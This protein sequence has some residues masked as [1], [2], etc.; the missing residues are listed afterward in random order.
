MPC[1]M[2]ILAVLVFLPMCPSAIAIDGSLR[3]NQDE[4]SCM[5]DAGLSAAQNMV[6]VTVH[7]D[8][9]PRCYEDKILSNCTLDAGLIAAQTLT[10]PVTITVQPGNYILH[11]STSC[12]YHNR[13]DIQIVG[14]GSPVVNCLPGTGCSFYEC[15]NI[16]VDDVTFIGCGAVHNSTST[17]FTANNYSV[18][19]Y[20]V[21]I[22]F[23]LCLNVTIVKINVCLSNGIGLV[24][25]ASAGHISINDSLFINNT[26]PNGTAGGGGV[27]IEFPQCP[28]GK[29]GPCANSNTSSSSYTSYSVYEFT[30]CHFLNNNASNGRFSTTHIVSSKTNS[31]HHAFG[32][33]GRTASEL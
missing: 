12:V 9:D 4:N 33:R 1:L 32:N 17:N 22:Y 25:I 30:R 20:Q 29:D 19:K 15:Q 2:P 26:V 6:N 31:D 21:A 23:E 24:V 13:S 5:Q 7:M 14:Q 11:S 27:Y 28:N 18:M 3:C 10:G 8:G 16:N